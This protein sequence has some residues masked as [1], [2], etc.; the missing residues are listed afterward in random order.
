ME[1]H[2]VGGPTA[3]DMKTATSSKAA[4]VVGTHVTSAAVI[5]VQ[6]VCVHHVELWMP[7]CLH[8][9]PPLLWLH[10]CVIVYNGYCC[11]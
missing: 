11:C 2:C 3:Q 1:E 10:V 8:Y 5:G 4:S 9:S 6:C 7:P